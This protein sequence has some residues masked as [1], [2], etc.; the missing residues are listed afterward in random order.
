MF[1]RLR[2]WGGFATVFFVA[3]I[4]YFKR[5]L[6]HFDF[7]DYFWNRAFI[8]Q[9][10]GMY[11]QF[12][13]KIQDIGYVSHAIPF[14]NFLGET[15]NFHKDLM[16]IT[17][18]RTDPR[19]IGIKITLFPAE[20]YAFFGW[21]GVIVAPAYLAF[22]YCVNYLV[23]SQVF[24]FFLVPDRGAAKAVC[25]IFL[26]RLLRADGR[27]GRDVHVQEPDPDPADPV[28]G[29]AGDGDPRDMGVARGRGRV[30]DGAPAR[31]GIRRSRSPL[32]RRWPRRYR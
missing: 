9:M 27:V 17:E 11:E 8:G 20:A 5:D 32:P 14:A 10:A 15:S 2:M 25:R 3:F 21:L 29:G 30:P 7:W 23:I 28:S 16:L 13:L 4:L 6:L 24:R 22:M 1:L 12:N 26:C 19:T 18:N 31:P